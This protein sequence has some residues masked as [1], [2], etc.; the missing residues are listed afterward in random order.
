MP[1]LRHRLV[2]RIIRAVR[3]RPPPADLA[4]AARRVREQRRSEKQGPTRAVRR[5][6][7][8]TVSS[9]EGFP[10]FTAR[11]RSGGSGPPI[12]YLHGGSY[13]GDI[14]PQHWGIVAGLVADLGA[15]VT[16]PQ[17]P[18]APEA[19]WRDSR[20]TLLTLARGEGRPPVLMGDSAGGGLALALAAALAADGV[21]APALVLVA[22]WVDLTVSQ[23]EE[24]LTAARD[25]W[26]EPASLR[27][28]GRLWAGED[29]PRRPELSP[30][31]ADLAG[32]PPTLV[33]AGTR[34]VLF[35]QSELL[36]DRLQESGVRV[37]TVT[38]TGLVHVYPLLPVPE[39]RAARLR[40]R[41]FLAAQT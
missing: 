14:T 3:H 41:E 21:A 40:I 27:L 32:L 38:G 37:E 23:P 6:A 18:L 17:Y 4:E 28:S 16:V 20:E 36:V 11:P 24:A 9:A 30:L 19:T 35:G 29:D 25:P 8:V 2:V 10:V 12:L 13:T 22:P 39:A 33:V 1:S 26:L 5:V 34:D 31:Y 15:T 7:E